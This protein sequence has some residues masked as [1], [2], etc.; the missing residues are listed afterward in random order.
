MRAALYR[1]ALVATRHNPVI[2]DFYDRLVAADRGGD[3]LR[4][5]KSNLD[6]D[7]AGGAGGRGKGNV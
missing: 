3:S 4:F 1:S 2:R 5:V 6:G 7:G